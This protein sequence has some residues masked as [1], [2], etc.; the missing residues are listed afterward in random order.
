M[1]VADV[2]IGSRVGMKETSADDE[3]DLAELDV[4]DADDGQRVDDVFLL[5]RRIFEKVFILFGEK[6][7]RTTIRIERNVDS[8]IGVETREAKREESATAG[9]TDV[10]IVTTMMTRR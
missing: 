1:K 4:V 7:A 8:R 10:A 6:N 3:D 9:Q 5:A 2:V